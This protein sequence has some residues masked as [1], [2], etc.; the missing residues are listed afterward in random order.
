MEMIWSEVWWLNNLESLLGPI[1]PIVSYKL[2]WG[3]QKLQKLWLGCL[4]TL[5]KLQNHTFKINWPVFTTDLESSVYSKTRVLIA[6]KRKVLRT[7]LYTTFFWGG[8]FNK[9]NNSW[10]CYFLTLHVGNFGLNSTCSKN[11]VWRSC[12]N[13]LWGLCKSGA[14]E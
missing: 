6:H 12:N 11:C 9:L 8:I 10:F 1:Y 7:H 14:A 2:F 13:F 4:L 3:T 5:I